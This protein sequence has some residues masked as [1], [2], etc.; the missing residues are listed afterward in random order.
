M[1][2]TTTTD[3]AVVI[4]KRVS[5]IVT[6]TLIQNAIMLG[7]VKDFTAQVSAGMDRLD[8][9]LFNALAVQDVIENANMTPQ[10]IVLQTAQL[11]LNR[12]KSIPFAIS[13]KASIQSKAMLV[14]EAV[15][16]GAKSLSA[17]VDNYLLGLID[18]NASQ[19]FALSLNALEDI[20]KAKRVL[21]VQNTPKVGRYL[22][23]SPLFIEAL[24]KNSGIIDADKFGN[25]EPKQAGYITRIY[26]FTVLE[27]SSASIIDGGF[28]VFCQDA[29]GFARQIAPKFESQRQVLGQKTD[30]ALTHM[31][32]GINLDPAGLRMAVF[33]AD[34]V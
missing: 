8:V 13:D 32:G 3:T 2:I 34:G 11:S 33:D 1:A 29:I 6:E 20:A 27:S 5:E 25:S 15:K 21:D 14:S 9:P 17:E 23:A 30:Y 31:Y 7:A 16:N 24:L 26:G 19:R 28:Q 10:S 22:V 4:E 18:A 12:H